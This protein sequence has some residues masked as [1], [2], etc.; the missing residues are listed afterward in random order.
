MRQKLHLAIEAL[1]AAGHLG[2]N[3]S[4]VLGLRGYILA[5]SGRPKAALSVL[6]AMQG[7]SREGYFPAGGY[8][9]GHVSRVAAISKFVQAM[10]VFPMTVGPKWRAHSLACARHHPPLTRCP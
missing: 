6:E 5:K 3:N 7:I 8:K 9:M 2:A 10:Y 1:S 4:K